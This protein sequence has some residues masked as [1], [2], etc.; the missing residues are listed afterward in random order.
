MKK[1]L[2]LMLCF[3]SAF[4]LEGRVAE[5]INNVDLIVEEKLNEKGENYGDIYTVHNR[6]DFPIRFSIKLGDSVNAVDNLTKNTIIVEPNQ[7]ASVGTVTMDD[8]TKESNWSYEI[9]IKPD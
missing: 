7:T 6:N 2:I 1:L 4:S 9:Q 8:P 5:S 3:A